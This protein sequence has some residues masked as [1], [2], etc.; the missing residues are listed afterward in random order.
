MLQLRPYQRQAVDSVFEWFEGEGHSA[1]PL[2]VLPTGTGKSLVLSEICRQSIAEYGEMKIVVVTHVMELIAQ[3][4]AEMMRQWPQADA[5]IYSAGIGKRQHTPAIVFCGIQSVHAKAHLFQKVDFVIVDEAH[6][7]PRKVNTMYQKFLNSLRVANPHMK[8]IG[9]TATPYRMDTGTL[10]TGDGALFDGI[11]YEYSVL[12][13]IREGFLS[14]IVTK[15]TRVALNTSGVHTRGGE[16]IQ[17]ELQSA[18]D[19][20]ETNRLA[21]NEI[22][23]W[24]K[25]R[26][27]WLV[28]G[29]GV[30]HCRH[31]QDHFLR[32]GIICETIF[33]DTPKED[34]AQII[35]EFKRGEVQALCSMGVLTTGFNAP[36][37][38]LIAMLRPTQ[39][40]GLYVQIVGR[41]MRIA[42]GK[43]DCLILDFARNILRHGPVDAITSNGKPFVERDGESEG[44]LVK[45]CPECKSVM[46]LSARQCL[47]CG[48]EFQQEIQIAPTASTLPVLSTAA[49]TYWLDVEEV[50]YAVHT[51]V[52]KPDSM[53]VTYHC[54]FLKYSEWICFNHD[55][56]A[57]QKA[58]AW[59]RKRS[60]N[61]PPENVAEAIKRRDE[62]REPEAI[63]VKRNGKFDEITQHRFD[64]PC[65]PPGEARLSV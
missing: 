57:K 22:I 59:W 5:G 55:G 15:N 63:Q 48:Y 54:G 42:E 20:D 29:S 62:L 33:G 50:K 1:N 16:F 8:I 47:D 4:Y 10:H 14:N 49:P 9:L 58:M 12:D 34:R 25:D 21:V 39:S 53:K 26:R 65:V 13:A 36:N 52:G 31:L 24:G 37:V 40:P 23:E 11:C 7:I 30:E 28:F 17:A 19:I 32:R 6:L 45:T 2:I 56:Y 3:N 27:S 64:V 18:V 41:G 60:P 61:S 43:K 38:D 51:K 46:H 35:D 44:A